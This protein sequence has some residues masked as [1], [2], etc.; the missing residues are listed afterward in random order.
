MTKSRYNPADYLPKP[1]TDKPGRWVPVDTSYAP[2]MGRVLNQK[3]SFHTATGARPGENFVS[4]SFGT[5]QIG[6]MEYF[7]KMEGFR[8]TIHAGYRP[9]VS[10]IR[11]THRYVLDE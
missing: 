9:D 3:L 1:K 7:M 11:W 2:T 5:G 8:G 4:T 10:E 6:R